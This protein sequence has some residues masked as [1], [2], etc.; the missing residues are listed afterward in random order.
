M[1]VPFQ[2]YVILTPPDPTWDA[3]QAARRGEP[4]PPPRPWEGIFVWDEADQ[5]AHEEAQFPDRESALAWARNN[6][7]EPRIIGEGQWWADELDKRRYRM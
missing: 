7:C 1:A 3:E 2:S 6:G 5:N 4:S